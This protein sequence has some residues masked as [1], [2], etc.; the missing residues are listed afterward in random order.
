MV[1]PLTNPVA[2]ALPTEIPESIQVSVESLGELESSLTVG[3]IQVPEGVS[4]LTAP[5]VGLAQ[6]ARPRVEQEIGE[7]QEGVGT[8]EIVPSGGSEAES[9]TD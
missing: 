3:D 9:E 8:E 2:A 4:I 1:L 5:D 7:L 6:I